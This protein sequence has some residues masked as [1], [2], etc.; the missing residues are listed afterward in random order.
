MKA[1][2]IAATV[3][4][5]AL[6]IQARADESL[7]TPKGA[8]LFGHKV[9]GVGGPNV[10]NTQPIGPA[11]KAPTSRERMAKG[12]SASDPDL[13]R[14]GVYTG[15]NPFGNQGREFEIA[16]LGKGKECEAGCTKPCCDK[17]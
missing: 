1:L 6:G 8:E 10:A 11:A 4:L 12:N 3:G 2:M 7:M 13:I 17:K 15:R 14:S 5:M 16:P 9:T